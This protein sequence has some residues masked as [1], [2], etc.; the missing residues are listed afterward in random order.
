MSGEAELPYLFFPHIEAAGLIR[1]AFSTRLGGESAGEYSTFNLGLHVG[2]NRQS[3]LANRRRFCAALEADLSDLVAA[4]QE[5]TDNIAVVTPAERGRGAFADSNALPATDALIT[6]SAGVVL[7]VYSADC[8]PVLLLDP[9]RRA[10]GLVHAGWRGTAAGIT[11][12]T[13]RRM[14]TVFG[15]EPQDCLAGIGP[16]IGPCCYTV[17]RPVVSRLQKQFAYWEDLIRAVGPGEWKLDLPEANRRQLVA[18][19][20]AAANIVVGH[21]CTACRGDLF[22]SHRAANGRTGRMAAG[23]ALQ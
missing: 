14:T 19:G 20:L 11:A 10:V 16:S 5:H 22:F 3:V 9:R 23:A 13:L 15:T 12:K 7:S 21:L 17:D 18:S 2:D 8:V 4:R 1:H 6:N